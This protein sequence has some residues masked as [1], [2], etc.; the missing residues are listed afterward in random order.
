MK[1][2]VRWHL[3]MTWPQSL[4]RQGLTAVF[5]DTIAVLSMTSRCAQPAGNQSHAS[6]R[7]FVADGF[8]HFC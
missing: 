7:T 2:V 5:S 8:P 6:R 4:L 1:R 3:M